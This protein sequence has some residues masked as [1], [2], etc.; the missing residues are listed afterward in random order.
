[1]KKNIITISLLL[2]GTYFLQSCKKFLE[3]EPTTSVNFDNSIVDLNSMR[4]SV[5]GAYSQFKDFNYYGRNAFLMPDLLADNLFISVRNGGRAVANNDYQ[6]IST[7]VYSRDLWTQAYRVAANANFVLQKAPGISVLES[8]EVEKVQLIG[9]A[10][11]ITALA[12]FDLLRFFSMPYQY[13]PNGSHPGVPLV[14]KVSGSISN[15]SFP[16]RSTVKEGYDLVLENLITAN[17]MMPLNPVNKGVVT[18]SKTRF[19]KTAVQAL[20]SRVYLYMGNWPEAIRWSDSTILSN[21]FKLLTT[22]K[23]VDGF[24]EKSNSESLLEIAFS[25][26]DNQ[27]T[28]ML[29]YFF[30]QSAYGDALVT[31]NLYNIY[32]ASDERRKFIFKSKRSKAEDPAYIVTKFANVTN[33]NENHKVIRLSE[34]YLN[35]AE[36]YAQIGEYLKAQKDLD[37][38]RQ[39]AEPS[40]IVSTE[41]G[42]LLIDKILLERRK[43]F[44]FEGHRLFDL[45]RNN[46]KF[47]KFLSPLTV[48]KPTEMEVDFPQRDELHLRTIFPIPQREIDANKSLVGQQNKGY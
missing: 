27:G 47:T 22:D 44:A 32:K 29:S 40:A 43:E 18:S 33:Y 19:S 12:Y 24:K 31:A 7:D 34:V 30:N 10:H 41:I 1:M 5:L 23:L 26:T 48:G 28:D 45:I 15:L 37:L 42:E 46:R 14:K 16:A 4:T 38:I 39:R 20:L 17:G 21:K 25:Q 13:S 35:R 11:A 6:S 2:L 8:Q 3:L 36:A 9:E